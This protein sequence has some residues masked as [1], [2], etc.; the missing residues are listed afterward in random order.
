MLTFSGFNPK[1]T[2]LNSAEFGKKIILGYIFCNILFLKSNYT[3][4]ET[5]ICKIGSQS[6]L[7]IENSMS[8]KYLDA[9]LLPHA[10]PH[11]TQPHLSKVMMHKCLKN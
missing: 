10:P 1:I 9:A 11:Y 6:L 5:K 8:K 2:K 3:I 4:T 7:C